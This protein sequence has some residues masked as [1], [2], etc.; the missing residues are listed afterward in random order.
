MSYNIKRSNVVPGQVFAFGLAAHFDASR[1][2]D[3]V[4]FRLI[5]ADGLTYGP[6]AVR[7]AKIWKPGTLLVT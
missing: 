3:V 4:Y 1:A 5:R 6:S 7:I 2:S